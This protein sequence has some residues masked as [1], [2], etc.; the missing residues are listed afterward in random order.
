MNITH[1]ILLSLAVLLTATAPAAAQTPAEKLWQQVYDAR[2]KAYEANF[3]KLPPDILK[4]GDLMGVWPGGGLYVIPAAKLGSGM[5]A[6]TTFGL[7]NPDMPTTVTL[8]DVKT[9]DKTDSSGRR[10]SSTQGTLKKKENIRPRTSRPGYGYEVIVLAAENAEWPLWLL[11]WSAKA[12]LIGDVDLLGRV[13]KYQ[14]FTVEQIRIGDNRAVNVLFAKAQ[15]PLPA[16]IQL[17]NGKAELIVATVITEEEMR[18]SMKNG[19][20]GLLE[21][22]RGAGVGQRSV[23]NRNSVVKRE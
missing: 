22:L 16:D 15:A 21:A 18:W 19:R 7:S 20:A 10:T 23:L 11:Q 1:R 17:P 4:L 5:V 2:T 3:G 6:Y 13:E 14:G 9:E 8:A 12:E